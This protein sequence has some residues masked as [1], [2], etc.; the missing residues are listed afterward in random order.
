MVTSV[1]FRPELSKRSLTLRQLCIITMKIAS[2]WKVA[3]SIFMIF[4]TLCRGKSE[5]PTLDPG[6][7]APPFTLQS[8]NG[9]VK[10]GQ[11]SAGHTVYPPLVFLAYTEQS[12]FLEALV[13]NRDS[14]EA[15]IEHS[16][17]NTH[18][19]FMSWDDSSCAFAQRFRLRLNEILRTY[20]TKRK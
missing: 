13:H 20:H 4:S 12:A 14:L 10:Y 15:L 11:N 8:L 17:E 7:K 9:V 18:Y 19:V 16:P 2:L 3:L 1:S 5:T 6:D